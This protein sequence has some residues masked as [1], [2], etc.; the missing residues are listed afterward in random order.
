MTYHDCL[1]PIKSNDYI[2]TLLCEIMWQTE[3]IST[4]L[5]ATQLG[6]MVT[7]LM[8]LLPIRSHDHIIWFCKITWQRKIIIHPLMQ[9][10][11]LSILTVWGSTIRSSLKVTRSFDHVVLQGHINYFSCCITNTTRPMA[12]KLGKVV[13]YGKKLQPIKSHNP[14]NT[15]SREVKW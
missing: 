12:T 3:N 14:V 15:G 8:W 10:L 7:Y 9:C 13:T 11:W 6:R 1:L 4:I 2:I 5:M